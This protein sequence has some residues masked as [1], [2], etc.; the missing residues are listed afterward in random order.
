MT[1]L[2]E[3]RPATA[4]DPRTTSSDAAVRYLALG[5]VVGFAAISVVN[6]LVIATLDRRREL[7]LLRAL[8]AT[9]RQSLRLLSAETLAGDKITARLTTAAGNGSAVNGSADNGGAINGSTDNGGADTGATL[10]NVRS[11]GSAGGPPASSR[12]SPP[13]YSP[14]DKI[15]PNRSASRCRSRRPTG[16]RSP[17]WPARPSWTWCAPWARTTC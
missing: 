14:G 16:P 11:T 12:I 6:T 4:G 3:A 9:R 8:G 17:A 15:G 5:L 1:G 7:A 2:R 13:K 10:R